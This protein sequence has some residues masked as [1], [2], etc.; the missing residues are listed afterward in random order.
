MF[1]WFKQQDSSD[2]LLAAMIKNRKQVIINDNGSIRVDLNNKEVQER[3]RKDL[4]KLKQ[5]EA[6]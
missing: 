3:I 1:G 2:R 6:L 5:L 4:E